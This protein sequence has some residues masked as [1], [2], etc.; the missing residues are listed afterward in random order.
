MQYMTQACDLALGLT[1]NLPGDCSAQSSAR[2]VRNAAASR[3]VEP[4][5][6]DFIIE[7][8]TCQGTV[9]ESWVQQRRQNATALG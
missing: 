2:A 4:D 7:R 6:L 3:N 8:H 5:V 1:W 9:R